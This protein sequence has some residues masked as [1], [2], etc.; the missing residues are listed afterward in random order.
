MKPVKAWR[1]DVFDGDGK[2]KYW[3]VCATK[4]EAVGEG[5]SWLVP[6]ERYEVS[7]V[8]LVPIEPKKRRAKR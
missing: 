1:V 8:M 7:R 4:A 5:Q 3:I 2:R 6:G